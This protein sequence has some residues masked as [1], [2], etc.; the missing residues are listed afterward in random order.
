M[1]AITS[2]ESEVKT[3]TPVEDV[4]G[5]IAELEQDYLLQSYARYPLLLERG[6]ECYVYDS[7]GN[8]Y[9]DLISGI[10]VNRLD[11]RIRASRK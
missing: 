2:P 1:S 8:R 11:T 9:L 4:L 5:R 3:T 7:G 10:G 6:R